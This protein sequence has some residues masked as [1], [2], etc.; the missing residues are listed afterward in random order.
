[1]TIIGIAYQYWLEPFNG[2]RALRL[3]VRCSL[4]ITFE[5]DRGEVFV[6]R[7]YL[8]AVPEVDGGGLGGFGASQTVGL[9]GGVANER[10]AVVSEH[11][12]RAVGDVLT[13]ATALA[14]GD[15]LKRIGRNR[16]ALVLFLGPAFPKL[17]GRLASLRLPR[18]LVVAWVTHPTIEGW[19]SPAGHCPLRLMTS[20]PARPTGCEE[21]D[22]VVTWTERL[23]ITSTG[24]SGQTGKQ[25]RV[26]LQSLN[27]WQ[28][29]ESET[30]EVLQRVLEHG[31]ELRFLGDT[32]GPH[33][34]FAVA[35]PSGCL[36]APKHNALPAAVCAL[37][38]RKT[39]H[40]EKESGEKHE[41]QIDQ[42]VGSTSLRGLVQQGPFAT[43]DDRW[44][45]KWAAPVAKTNG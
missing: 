15:V 30:R 44:P 29:A 4:C 8:F 31:V 26:V 42:V 45:F 10:A 1:M 16:K 35:A 17:V 7:H 41:A 11:C 5:D 13:R 25:E 38:R 18:D 2:I 39:R 32:H 33:G 19:C 28:L 20:M 36:V 22:L 34:W 21:D 14:L 37:W 24:E 23:H 9:M 6:P 40:S 27:Q 3:Y 12:E 43:A